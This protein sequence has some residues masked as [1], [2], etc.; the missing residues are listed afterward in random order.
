MGGIISISNHSSGFYNLPHQIYLDSGDHLI[1]I[2]L[3]RT[4]RLVLESNTHLNKAPAVYVEM[5]ISETSVRGVSSLFP[6]STERRAGLGKRSLSDDLHSPLTSGTTWR[7]WNPAHHRAPEVCQ[8]RR[9]SSRGCAA[10]SAPRPGR[11]CRPRRRGSRNSPS[12]WP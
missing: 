6:D 1:S 7:R 4:R 11:C 3:S 9:P 8:R 5:L 2:S 10:A 12:A